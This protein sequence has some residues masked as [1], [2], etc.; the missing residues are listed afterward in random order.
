MA[1]DHL[2]TASLSVLDHLEALRATFRGEKC[3]WGSNLGAQRG[4]HF[5]AKKVQKGAKTSKGPKTTTLEGN[6]EAPQRT[7]GR[8][9]A[10]MP[11]GNVFV[12]GQRVVL[13]RDSGN[14]LDR[15]P[16]PMGWHFQS[17]GTRHC[18][19]AALRPA[20][21]S[22]TGSLRS[23]QSSPGKLNPA[24]WQCLRTQC[25]L[26]LVGPLPTY[27]KTRLSTLP[28]SLPPHT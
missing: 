10:K 8:G 27:T 18:G 14:L 17:C 7:R 16:L 19:T 22:G 15:T 12:V 20:C 24:P 4:T 6:F 13:G 3:S 2:Q 5:G 1:S 25:H 11:S 21:G 26:I 28:P 9:G 23:P